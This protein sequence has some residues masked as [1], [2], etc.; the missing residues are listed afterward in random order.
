MIAQIQ[1]RRKTAFP[2]RTRPI[3]KG[4]FTSRLVE[5]GAIPSTRPPVRNGPEPHTVPSRRRPSSPQH[6]LIQGPPSSKGMSALAFRLAFGGVSTRRGRCGERLSTSNRKG[7]SPRRHMDEESL[8]A[9]SDPPSGDADW[10][11]RILGGGLLSSTVQAE[12][13]R[14][15]EISFDQTPTWNEMMWRTGAWRFERIFNRKLNPLVIP[16]NVE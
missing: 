2:D 3:R 8:R 7:P 14:T 5:D 9:Q 12:T 13:R 10:S 4:D 15:I 1:P 16:S 6:A 11:D